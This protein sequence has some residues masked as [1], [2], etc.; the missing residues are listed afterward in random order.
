MAIKLHLK[1]HNWVPLLLG[2]GPNPDCP[3]S[4]GL[5]HA[6]HTGLGHELHRGDP[7]PTVPLVQGLVM[8]FTQGLV[9]NYTEEAMTSPD[10]AAF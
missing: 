10:D 5:G 9:M 8:Q 1:S 2:K 4:S 7:I 6:V 3:S